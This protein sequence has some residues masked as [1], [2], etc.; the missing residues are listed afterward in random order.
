MVCYQD[1]FQKFVWLDRKNH[2][3]SDELELMHHLFIIVVK[4]LLELA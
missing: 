2:F 3:V 1:Y 4:E